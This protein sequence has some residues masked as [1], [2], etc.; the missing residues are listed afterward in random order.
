MTVAVS[1]QELVQKNPRG[2]SEAHRKP[3]EAAL[4]GA[5]GDSPSIDL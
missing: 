4:S 5:T 2:E 1:S 3:E